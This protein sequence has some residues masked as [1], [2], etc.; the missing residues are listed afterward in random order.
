MENKK[1][2]KEKNFRIRFTGFRDAFRNPNLTSGAKAVLGDLLG[3][4]GVNGECFPSQ[5]TLAKNH[6]KTSRQIRNLLKELAFHKLIEWERG[7]KGRSNRY[8]FNKE[9][10]FQQYGDIRKSISTHI[11]N[12]IPVSNG[13]ILPTN[14]VNESNQES[15]QSL[16]QT[17]FKISCKRTL[18]PMEEKQLIEWCSEYSQG[19][20][21]DAIKEAGNRHYPIIKLG[22]IR[23]ILNDWK[24]GG[25]PQPK[26]K[27]QAC[28]INGCEGGFIQNGLGS[29]KE[30]YCHKEYETIKLD[31]FNKW[32]NL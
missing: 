11:G 24:L 29:V 12:I 15:S 20:V 17:T 32:G 27:F 6:N 4:A 7:K 8:S 3:Y 23:N 14:V 9:I 21:I 28:G 1:I 30:C 5:E 25:K 22:L 2:G 19:W 13:N 31:W 18:F 26:P 10:Y 16:L